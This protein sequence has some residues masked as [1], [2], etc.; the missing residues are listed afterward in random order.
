MVRVLCEKVSFDTELYKTA[1]T[2]HDLRPNQ[3]DTIASFLPAKDLHTF[4]MG[5]WRAK[6]KYYDLIVHVEET[7][8]TKMWENT[9]NELY[10]R[11]LQSC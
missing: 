6:D 10:R 1:A 5:V 11:T 7:Q 3:G 4:W 8:V 2:I 9:T